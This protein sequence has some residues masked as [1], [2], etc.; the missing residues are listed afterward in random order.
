MTRYIY[1]GG[2]DGDI[3]KPTGVPFISATANVFDARTGGT[4]ITDLQNMSGA[5]I[6]AITTD[7]FGQ[8]IFYGP[9]NYTNVLWLDF[10]TGIRWGLSPKDA[11]L[12][13][14]QSIATQRAT[15]AS[16]AGF[17]TKAHLPYNAADPLEQAL[18]NALDPMVIPRFANAAARDAAFPSPQDGDT[19]YRTDRSSRQVYSAATGAWTS[20]YGFVFGPTSTSPLVINNTTAETLLTAVTVPANYSLAGTVYRLTAYGT[21][22]QATSTTPTITFRSRISGLTGPAFATTAF[23]AASNASPTARPWRLELNVSVIQQGPS[24]AGQWLGNMFSSSSITSTGALPS[25]APSVRLD[26]TAI[27]TRDTTVNQDLVLTVQWDSA[28]SSNSC[29]MHGFT[30]ERVN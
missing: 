3:I 27:Q 7:A 6:T 17:T 30:W 4:Q 28:S 24:P 2:G 21:V 13:A 26:G 16:G 10:G 25:T 15:D 23:T 5:N 9:D 8:A 29:T 20:Q 14:K 19:C 22:V 12:V 1:G 18:A 11:A